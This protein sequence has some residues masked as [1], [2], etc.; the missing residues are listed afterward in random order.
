MKMIVSALTMTLA[1]S[2]QAL[3]VYNCDFTAVAKSNQ[4]ISG[5]KKTYLMSQ[6]SNKQSFGKTA[7]D[8]Q[9][10]QGKLTGSVNGQPNFILGGTPDKGHFESAYVKGTVSCSAPVQTDYM[11]MFKPWGQFYSLDKNLSQGHILDDASTN[12]LY[13]GNICFVGNSKAV[14]EA[15]SAQAPVKAKVVDAYRVEFTFE[16]RFCTKP[17]G[18][19][20]DDYGCDEYQT[21][22]VTKPVMNCY[23]DGW[24]DPRS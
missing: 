5:S 13:H 1:M 4:G 24:V 19:N 12:Q 6:Y 9:V 3:E 15:I 22:T 7:L 20:P 10:A 16:Y 2:A 14:A 18:S 21:K 17:T 11:L 8:I 23:D